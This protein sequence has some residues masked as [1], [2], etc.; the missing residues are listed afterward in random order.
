MARLLLQLSS[1]VQST[2]EPCIVKTK[3]MMST[4]E[5]VLSLAQGE[6]LRPLTVLHLHGTR[7]QLSLAALGILQCR[8]AGFWRVCV[9][10]LCHIGVEASASCCDYECVRGGRVH[11]ISS[12]LQGWCTGV[13]RR[14]RLR[15]HSKPAARL[16]RTRMGPQWA[17]RDCATACKEKSS[18]RIA[19]RQCAPVLTP[20][21][22]EEPAHAS[23]CV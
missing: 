6:P 3:A 22:T 17:P 15:Q 21:H 16:W 5:G 11:Y 9:S 18:Q 8:S 20:R 2:D 10:D 4:V 1:R 14:V 19:S 13:R 12:T 23:L 7:L